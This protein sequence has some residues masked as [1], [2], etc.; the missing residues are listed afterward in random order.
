MTYSIFLSANLKKTCFLGGEKKEV[1]F[2]FFGFVS[3][4]STIEG[5]W[6]SKNKDFKQ[7]QKNYWMRKHV[8]RAEGN[9][10]K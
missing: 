9:L 10:M 3:V 2:L 6:C 8:S 7:K 5:Y 1:A 4:F